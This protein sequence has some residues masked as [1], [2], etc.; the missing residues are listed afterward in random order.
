MV[1]VKVG[2]GDGG[3]RGEPD[4]QQHDVE[5]GRGDP[6]QHPIGFQL[7]ANSRGGFDLLAEGN[8]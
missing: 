8:T 3:G 5:A 6:P 1:N 2:G 7:S 4:G